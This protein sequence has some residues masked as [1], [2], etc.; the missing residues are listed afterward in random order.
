[1][2]LL[3]RNATEEF[4]IHPSEREIPQ[5]LQPSGAVCDKCDQGSYK[6]SQ[7]SYNSSAAGAAEE[8]AAETPKA[9]PEATV[10]RGAQTASHCLNKREKKKSKAAGRGSVYVR[11]RAT[12]SRVRR[13]LEKKQKTLWSRK[14]P[15][16]GRAPVRRQSGSL[17]RGRAVLGLQ[18]GR[19]VRMTSGSFYK[20][21]PLQVS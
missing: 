7:I 11:P 9:T 19:C 8:N 5:V 4:M 17:V 2:I 1:M 14:E 12:T 16:R 10:R 15:I 18:W 13:R 6:C 3:R 21:G 20:S